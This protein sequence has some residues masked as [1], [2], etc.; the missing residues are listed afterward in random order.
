MITQFFT[1]DGENYTSQIRTI[2]KIVVEKVPASEANELNKR[3]KVERN[4]IKGTKIY[5]TEEY[6]E[7]LDIE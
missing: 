4:L 1:Y 3:V 5:V 7:S 2:G 6:S